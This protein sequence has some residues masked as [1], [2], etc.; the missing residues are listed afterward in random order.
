MQNFHGLILSI[1]PTDDARFTV[2]IQRDDKQPDVHATLDPAAVRGIPDR[3]R[4]LVNR[5][6]RFAVE[7]GAIVEIEP[8]P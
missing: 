4:E 7:D 1:S 3:K 2:R 5:R 6:F 8:A